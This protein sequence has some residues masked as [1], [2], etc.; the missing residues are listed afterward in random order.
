[1][2]INIV[3]VRLAG[4]VTGLGTLSAPLFD[5]TVTFVPPAGATLLSVTVQVVVAPETTLVG[6][7]ESAVTEA[8]GT[9]VTFELAE[10]PL[11]LAVTV[12]V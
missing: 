11:A 6:L 10:P 9:T 1:M 12:A 4:T 5:V 8:A 2:P 7:H 3:L